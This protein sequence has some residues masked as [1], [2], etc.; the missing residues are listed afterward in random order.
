[1]ILGALVEVVE[2]VE[3]V[4]VRKVEVLDDIVEFDD[5]RLFDTQ[6][7]NRRLLAALMS[8][9]HFPKVSWTLNELVLS[10]GSSTCWFAKAKAR[11]D[12]PV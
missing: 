3:I 8:C 12:I 9:C 10:A 4:E 7:S 2:M 5:N 1:M 6:L 11:V